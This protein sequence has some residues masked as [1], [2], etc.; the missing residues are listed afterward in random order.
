V[1][2]IPRSCLVPCYRSWSLAGHLELIQMGS[3]TSGLPALEPEVAWKA[4]DFM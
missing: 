4:S 1:L 2:T 3:E